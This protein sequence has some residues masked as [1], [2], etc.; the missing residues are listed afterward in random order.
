MKRSFLALGPATM[1]VLAAAGCDSTSGGEDR[2]AAQ[3]QA[4]QF[5]CPS[6]SVVS[7][8]L[9]KTVPT[10]HRGTVASQSL[11]CS[12]T[13]TSAGGAS[14]FVSVTFGLR[15]G[16]LG[17]VAKA[18]VDGRPLRRL[19]GLG[20]EAFQA[21]ADAKSGPTLFVRSGNRAVTVDEDQD[22]ATESSEVA[23][24]RVFL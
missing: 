10:V 6:A 4:K 13:D 7:K 9:G 22:G 16:E 17:R 2:S 5:T 1:I 20:D 3:Q 18:T 19:A 14:V 21:A 15:K 11:I 23:V 24:V 12:Y 8:A